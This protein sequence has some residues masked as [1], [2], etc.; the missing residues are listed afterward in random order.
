MEIKVTFL[1]QLK[2]KVER[3]LHVKG[4]YNGGILEMAMIIDHQ[5]PK[6]VVQQVVPELLQILKRH[7]EV[8]RN[9]RLNVVDWKGDAVIENRV[10]PMSMVM[11]SGFY[12]DYEQIPEKKEFLPL[13]EY[14][15]MYQARAKLIILVTDGSYGNEQP[16]LAKKSMQP[17]LGKKM[18]QIVI[19]ADS[20]EIL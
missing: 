4:N 20:M 9:V 10:S 18:M 1:Q 11:M 7:S 17:F 2:N 5:L 8:F 14:L 19:H 13:V 3:I 16:E 6:D 15:K 12:D